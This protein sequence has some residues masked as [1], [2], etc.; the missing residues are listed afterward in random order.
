MRW[1]D[2]KRRQMP[3][4]KFQRN[5]EHQ[6]PNQAMSDAIDVWSFSGDW[7]LLLGVF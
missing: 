5:F 6:G 4:F 1:R 7:M 3:S 2:E